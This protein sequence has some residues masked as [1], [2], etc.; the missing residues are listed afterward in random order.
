[1]TNPYEEAE[2]LAGNLRHIITLLRQSRH[3]AHLSSM[4]MHEMHAWLKDVYLEANN[5]AYAVHRR[6]LA[7]AERRGATSTAG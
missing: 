7:E 1:M 2:K 5:L 6:E 4:D 3:T